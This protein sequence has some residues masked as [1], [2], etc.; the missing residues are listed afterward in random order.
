VLKIN[1]AHLE[2]GVTERYVTPISKWATAVEADHGVVVD[3][4][5]PIIIENLRK[6]GVQN[7]KKQERRVF[8]WLDSFAG[9]WIHAAWEYTEKGGKTKRAGVCIGPEHGSVGPDLVKEAALSTNPRRAELP[10]R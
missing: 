2:M 8:D 1:N 6:A 4:F 5:A 3:R 9:V 7:T 10:P